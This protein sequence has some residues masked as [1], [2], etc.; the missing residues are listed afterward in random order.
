MTP[1]KRMIVKL[2][3]FSFGFC[4]NHNI[5]SFLDNASLSEIGAWN[6]WYFNNESWPLAFWAPY[7]SI[8]K[9]LSLFPSQILVCAT[10][11]CIS[12]SLFHFEIYIWWAL[13]QKHKNKSGKI[14]RHKF[15]QVSRPTRLLTNHSWQA[16]YLQQ[17]HINFKISPTK[18]YVHIRTSQAR[19][20]TTPLVRR[21]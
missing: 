16:C 13:L 10:G 17:S 21:Y 1:H 2:K 3:S 14:Y 12:I 19:K 8:Q 4:I 9:L 7:I 6:F 18:I 5:W 11:F 20:C 15:M